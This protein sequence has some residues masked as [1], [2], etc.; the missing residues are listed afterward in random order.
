[1][2]EK[3]IFIINPISGT[4]SKNSIPEMI[5]LGLEKELY[6]PE[7][8]F[9]EYRGH[10]TKLSREYLDK[11][12]KKIIAVGGDGTVNEV[13]TALINTDAS[14]GIVPIGSGNG[15]AR[16]L[17]IPMTIKKAVRQ[18]NVSDSIRIDYGMVNR[19]PFFCTCGTGF[20][21][22]VSM[23]FAKGNKRGIVS[24][25]EKIVKG[26]FAYK[27]Q[28][29]RIL[30]TNID[31]STDA[32]LLTF[33]NASQWGNNAYIAPKASLQDGKL[34]ISILSKLPIS[35]IPTLAFELFTKM[36]DKDFNV[37]SLQT[38]EITLY[39][40]T[41]GPFHYDGEPYEEGREITIKIIPK[42]L[43]VLVK[44]RY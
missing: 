12:V 36:I 6:D 42:G 14:L 30:G 10:G 37:S 18:L 28:H 3:I 38:K 43:N 35:A 1:M 40:E 29:Y 39:R 4:R 19:Q 27:P 17:E 25:L 16:H 9:T 21:A 13:A 11:G 34:D 32:F 44:R 24:Y 7:I 8:V 31:I 41:A 20:D 2:A 15:L 22:Y 5:H 26:Y 33:A 23:E